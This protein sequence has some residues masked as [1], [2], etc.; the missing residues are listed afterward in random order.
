V[1]LSTRPEERAGDDGLWDRAEAALRAVLARLGAP[2]VHQPGAG[3]FYGPKLEWTLHD[4]LGRPWQCGTIQFDLVMPARFG[5]CFVDR[6]G[7]RR[8]PVMLHRALYGSLERFLGILLE[9]HAGALPPWMAPEQVV[10]L[11]VGEAGQ[12]AAE[13]LEAEL[14]RT[15]LRSRIDADEGLAKRLARAHERK[16]PF[17]AILGAREAGAGT[18][19]VR[20]RGDQQATA[21]WDAAIAEL[22]RACARPAFVEAV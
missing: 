14:R 18:V 9:H 2:F 11:P 7:Q 13:R 1:A 8:T 19:T 3:A 17:Q 4:R 12:A 21:P 10:V 20:G 6:D 22:R 15:G 5:L 16:I